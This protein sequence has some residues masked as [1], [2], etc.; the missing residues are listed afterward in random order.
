MFIRTNE[1]RTAN[2]TLA[3]LRKKEKNLR[4]KIEQ[5]DKPDDC[6]TMNE[7]Q[8][9]RVLSRIAELEDSIKIMKG[10][11]LPKRERPWMKHREETFIT[12]Y[13]AV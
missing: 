3:D 9:I 11:M 10:E 12:A 2:K 13:G 5:E 1:I 6:L 8:L 4:I 7:K